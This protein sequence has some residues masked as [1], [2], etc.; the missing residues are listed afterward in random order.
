MNL[1][2]ILG[3]LVVKHVSILIRDRTGDQTSIRTRK[4]TSQLGRTSGRVGTGN[5]EAKLQVTLH[6]QLRASS[7]INDNYCV[8]KLQTRLLARSPT[9]TEALDIYSH[10]NFPVVS[11]VLSATGLPQ[12]KGLSRGLTDVNCQLKYVKGVSSVTHLSCVIP[13]TNVNNAAQNLPVGARL[14]NYWQTWL[15]LGA[16]PKVVQILRGGYTLPFGSGQNSQGLPQ[17]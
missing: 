16:S 14:Q 11:H 10:V 15:D 1:E 17:S 7:R 8:T 5:L 13:A 3:L 6:D 2:G 9:S 12:R 4:G